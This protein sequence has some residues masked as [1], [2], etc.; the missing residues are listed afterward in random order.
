MFM[1]TYNWFSNFV[2]HQNINH[3]E[4]NIGQTVHKYIKD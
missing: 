3:V 2:Y 4:H 1:S